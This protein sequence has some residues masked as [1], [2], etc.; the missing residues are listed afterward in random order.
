MKYLERKL[1]LEIQESLIP[2]K[3]VVLLGPRRIGKTVL[4]NQV[5]K[6]ITEP[7]LLLNGEDISTRELFIRRSVE[8]F[9]QLLDGNKLLVIDEAQKIPDIGNSL[10]LMIDEIPGLKILVTGSSAFDVENYTGEPLTGRKITFNLFPLS[11]QEYDQ[12]HPL[13]I[14]KDKMYERLVYGNYP[15]LLQLESK[16]QKNR[17]LNDLVT[18]YLLK[19]I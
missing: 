15:E 17:Y 16:A 10:K 18:S 1:K 13:L 8:N 12:V 7:Y 5:L 11:E 9:T 19:Y 6:E 14:R 4:I 2:N 3:V